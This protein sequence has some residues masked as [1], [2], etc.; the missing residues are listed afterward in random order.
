MNGKVQEIHIT[1]L[2]AELSGASEDLMLGGL[3]FTYRRKI[4]QQQLIPAGWQEHSAGSRN[5]SE[6]Q[7]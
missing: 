1:P 3:E 7:S 4:L 2:L 6:E 5:S